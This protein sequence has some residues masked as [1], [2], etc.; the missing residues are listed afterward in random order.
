MEWIL[1]AFIGA[2]GT[3]S[4]DTASYQ[5]PFKTQDEC[6]AARD[7]IIS[8]IVKP[9][10]PGNQLSITPRAVCISRTVQ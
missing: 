1:I 8:K 3:G 2:A 10:E 7:A 4:V 6:Q 5:I 9:R